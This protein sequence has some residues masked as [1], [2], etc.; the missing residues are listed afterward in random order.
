MQVIIEN[1]S[2][3]MH[4]NPKTGEEYKK[5]YTQ[6]RDLM[7]LMG[8][9]WG[10]RH[11]RLLRPS[12][13]GRLCDVR[14]FCYDLCVDGYPRV[15]CEKHSLHNSL[16]CKPEALRVARGSRGSRCSLRSLCRWR[17]A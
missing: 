13:T 7:M 5:E 6:F 12:G 14:K 3:A 15:N 10:K 16:Y 9:M 8:V 17:R 1:F 11:R 4:I 2:K